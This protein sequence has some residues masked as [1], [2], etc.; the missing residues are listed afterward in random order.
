MAV[1]I[2]LAVL[3]V[4]ILVHEWGHFIVA[5]KV[6]MRVDEFAIGFP[7]RIFGKKIGE[8]VYSLNAF[9]IGG[10][11]RILGENPTDPEALQHAERAFSSKSKWAQVAVLIAGVIMNVVLAFV[12]FTAAL[13][14]GTPTAVSEEAMSAS[15]EL[16][17]ADV[18]PGSPAADASIPRGVRVVNVVSEGDTLG[19]HTPSA[20][21]SFVRVHEEDPLIITYLHKG[22]E[23][24]VTIEPTAGVLVAE[25]E[26]R[27]VGM[28]LALIETVALS[29]PEALWQA[30]HMTVTGL[31]DI[32]IGVVGLLWDAVRFQAD[33]KEIAGPV[34][35]VGF[36]GE[37]SSFGITALLMFTAFISLN[38]AIINMLP[39]PALDGGRLLFVLIEAMK[40]SPIRPSWAGALNMLGFTLLI[41][42]MIAVTYN[43]ILKI[44]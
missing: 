44:I 22:E 3:F 33:L 15:A 32:T 17:V 14:I 25:P 6:G 20:F 8:T 42:L 29:L 12:L 7:P 35:I 37:A 36:V 19:T 26:R 18:M 11:V 30:G 24:T 38:L 4:L 31:R 27:V 40:G 39:F 28:G 43:D 13:A 16:V 1:L 23:I 34:G 41:L 2:F 5:K 9:P 21:Q 10:F